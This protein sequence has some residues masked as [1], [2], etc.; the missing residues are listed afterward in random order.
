MPA[1]RKPRTPRIPRSPRPWGED[2]EVIGS[3]EP[4]R[5]R[6]IVDAF[7]RRGITLRLT[8]DGQHLFAEPASLLT[9]RDL[10]KLATYKLNLLQFLL[11][12]RHRI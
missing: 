12:S 5:P 11:G 3:D 1:A 10:A 8:D 4:H 6:Q 2:R 7:A 9:V